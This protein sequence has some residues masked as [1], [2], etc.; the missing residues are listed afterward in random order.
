MLEREISSMC[1]VLI[2][3]VKIV[4]IFSSGNLTLK[5]LFSTIT[6]MYLSTTNNKDIFA[7]RFQLI[8][9]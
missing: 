1:V 8:R 2:L 6:R 9:V 5:Y 7:T 4:F 3:K